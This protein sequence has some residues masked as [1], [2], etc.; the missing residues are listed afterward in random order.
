[1]EEQVERKTFSQTPERMGRMEDDVSCDS[2]RPND[3][4]LGTKNVCS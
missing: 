4:A 1:M 2:P 3:D